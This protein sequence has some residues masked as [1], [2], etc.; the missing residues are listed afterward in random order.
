[1]FG[2]LLRDLRVIVK[3]QTVKRLVVC[4]CFGRHFCYR[5]CLLYNLLSL[6]DISCRDTTKVV[7]TVLQVMKFRKQETRVVLKSFTEN[8]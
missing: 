6:R 1:M 3:R 7:G 5:L 8:Q 2:F 4:V